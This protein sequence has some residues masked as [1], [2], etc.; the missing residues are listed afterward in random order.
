VFLDGAIARL[1]PDLDMV[2]EIAELSTHMA[3]TH[4]ATIAADLGVDTSAFSVDTEAIR[5]N[6]GVVDSG[7]TTLT[8]R[9]LQ[10]RRELIRKRL[11]K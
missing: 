6:F 10:K 8:H 1:A 5:A 2:S 4:G 3:T 9:D 7:E 11:G